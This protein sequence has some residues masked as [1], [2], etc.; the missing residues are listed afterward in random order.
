M[1]AIL[2]ITVALISIIA[3]AVNNMSY[4]TLLSETSEL[5]DFFGALSPIF[6]ADKEQEQTNE[7]LRILGKRIRRNLWSFYISLIVFFAYVSF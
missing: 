7:E 6:L 3:K 1:I 2:A 4:L 5:G